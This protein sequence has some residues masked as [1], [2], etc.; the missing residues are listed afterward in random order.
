MD[1]TWSATVTIQSLGYSQASQALSGLVSHVPTFALGPF[2]GPAPSTA[3][4][5]IS[6]SA[7]TFIMPQFDG[8]VEVFVTFSLIGASSSSA[9]MVSS[10]VQITADAPQITAVA[11]FV[12]PKTAFLDPNPCAVLNATRTLANIST[13][14]SQLDLP[15]F[16][17]E[18]ALLSDTVAQCVASTSST[19]DYSYAES[20]SSPCF[21]AT[22]S[23]TP[24]SLRVLGRNFGSG[25]SL[26]IGK[27]LFPLQSIGLVS[28]GANQTSVACSPIVYVSS[29]ELQCGIVSDLAVGP[30]AVNVSFAFSSV[31]SNTT[32]IDPLAVCPCGSYSYSLGDACA[33][34]PVN[35]SC[36]G[37]LE[38]PHTL[39]GFW[40]L[41]GREAE[42]ASERFFDPT[43]IPP[44]VAC[45]V[46]ALCLAGD[47]CA[48]GST[49]SLCSSCKDDGA[50]RFIRASDGGCTPCE[51]GQRTNTIAGLAT[52]LVLVV[53]VWVLESQGLLARWRIAIDE[54][55]HAARANKVMS[56]AARGR[57]VNAALAQ[58][59]RSAE[60]QKSLR[61]KIREHFG[62]LSVLGYDHP[63]RVQREKRVCLA[64][65]RQLTVELR[66]VDTKLEDVDSAVWVANLLQEEDPDRL[67]LSTIVKIGL[68]F[69]QTLAALSNYMR[70]RNSAQTNIKTNFLPSMLNAFSGFGSLGFSSSDVQCMLPSLVLNY[71]AHLW[72]FIFLPAVA[73]FA[74]AALAYFVV[75]A[76]TYF[77]SAFARYR[78]GAGLPNWA[79]TGHDAGVAA[80]TASA[81]WVLFAS[82]PSSI[83]ELA[84]AQNCA[85][86]SD[87]G[88][89][90]VSPDISCVP[91]SKYTNPFLQLQTIALYVGWVYL[92]FPLL[93]AVLLWWATRVQRRSVKD[94]HGVMGAGRGVRAATIFLSVT[95]FAYDGYR[96]KPVPRMWEMLTMARKSI[97]MGLSTGFL[98][99]STPSMQIV[100]TMALLCLSL[101]LHV[102][103]MPYRS[104]LVNILELFA[105][106]GELFFTFGVMTRVGVGSVTVASTD[107]AA[108][109][110]QEVFDVI[111]L[112]FNVPFLLCWCASFLD[113]ALQNSAWSHLLTVRLQ[114][115]EK[116]M[117]QRAL[118]E[119]AEAEAALEGGS[120]IGKGGG[121]G[122][123]R[124]KAFEDEEGQG[125]TSASASSRD[126]E[127]DPGPGF[128]SSTAVPDDVFV[129]AN[130]LRVGGKQTSKV[131]GRG[132]LGFAA[133]ATSASTAAAAVAATVPRLVTGLKKSRE[134]T[135]SA[136]SMLPA[137]P[138][139]LPELE[140][141]EAIIVGEASGTDDNANQLEDLVTT[142]PVDLPVPAPPQPAPVP[143]AVRENLLRG[144]ARAASTAAALPLED[145]VA[146]SVQSL[147]RA[148]RI[149]RRLGPLSCWER[150]VDEDEDCYY[151][152]SVT[153]ESVWELTWLR[154]PERSRTLTRVSSKLVSRRSMRRLPSPTGDEDGPDFAL[155]D[156]PPHWTAVADPDSGE[157]YFVNTKTD[158]VSWT[159]PARVP[160]AATAAEVEAAGAAA[161]AALAAAPLRDLKPTESVA[162]VTGV[163][164]E[165]GIKSSQLVIFIDCTLSNTLNGRSSFGGRSLH[166]ISNPRSPNPYVTV[167]RV[168]GKALE[169]FDSDGLFPLYGFGDRST[170]DSAV[171]A[172]HASSTQLC[173]GISGVLRAYRAGISKVLLAGPTSFAPAIRRTIEHVKE[174]A[175]RELTICLIIADG[176]VSMSARAATEAA[177]NEAAHY[178]I[179][180]IIVGV[181]DGPWDKLE[182][183]DSGWSQTRAIDN[184]CF[185]ELSKVAAEA[186]QRGESID[187]ALARECLREMPTFIS[188]AK[189]LKLFG[190]K[191]SQVRANARVVAGTGRFFGR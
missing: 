13:S 113:A 35:A 106:L 73:P 150:L 139:P 185:V 36:A 189:R 61:A 172:F 49:A 118:A 17:P 43:H 80:A 109:N 156:L 84:N 16:L 116:R 58:H 57:R 68:T 153:G 181:G 70:K 21:R 102:T 72:V 85:D 127:S 188:E 135:P 55:L 187:E 87:G 166:D 173:V 168:L 144:L 107:A 44:F 23:S 110:E 25:A 75:F 77:G 182:A 160:G 99:L 96:E 33:L 145:R 59:P 14:E 42:W 9:T 19:F 186:R 22:S 136:L 31:N 88:F 101:V 45:P 175:T 1:G 162:F 161:A 103:V 51:A 90:Y 122:Q 64:C 41:H 115:R 2:G 91:D 167:I 134:S 93:M 154:P 6:F 66:V 10:S 183:L 74:T 94:G 52:V 152:N 141:I 98:I 190:S 83:S 89:L 4:L 7:L 92:C 169:P 20:A 124:R 97:F 56:T 34:C 114:R 28:A 112:L 27:V 46:A 131:L 184:V 155:S 48:N 18:G 24:T 174:G 126:P 151:C 39:A 159:P 146:V 62:A 15:L 78:G 164:H 171:F 79:G 130:P 148:H 47:V 147:Y 104:N 149:R 117:R 37:G 50:L 38:H 26:A 11:A 29:R 121:R 105:L 123:V 133:T 86:E 32:G 60:V 140:A 158:E 108:A 142:A 180:V 163:M 179:S 30:V 191:W 8:Q 63:S 143:A 129:M 137:P 95:E 170:S 178:P 125:T 40:N 111:S 67:P 3:I 157:V 5:N 76:S 69:S 177:L 82:I 53:F 12:D 176:Q 138:L 165:L 128:K 54:R 71:K 120:G 65:V 132:R 100:A 119:E 81:S